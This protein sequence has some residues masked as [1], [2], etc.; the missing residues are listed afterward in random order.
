MRTA[1]G[2]IL[3]T[4]CERPRSDLLSVV[5]HVGLVVGVVAQDAG[6]AVQHH[7]PG[8]VER[9]GYGHDVE[10]LLAGPYPLQ[11]TRATGAGFHRG[12][13]ERLSMLVEHVELG[14]DVSGLSG[15]LLARAE[16]QAG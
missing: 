13:A 6:Y 16:G 14:E 15:K 5:P 7:G 9:F 11:D 3:A 10:A 12:V 2:W 1:S 8:L 4:R